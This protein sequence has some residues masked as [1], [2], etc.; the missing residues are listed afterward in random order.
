MTMFESAGVGE[1][2]NKDLNINALIVKMKI[3]MFLIFTQNIDCG[4]TLEP[5][6]R[7]GSNEHPQLLEQK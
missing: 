7:G 4:Y 5:T 3:D 2:L 6:R 1:G